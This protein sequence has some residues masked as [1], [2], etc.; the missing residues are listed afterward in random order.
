MQHHEATIAKYSDLVRTRPDVLALIIGGS[1]ARGTER[2]DSDV[3]VYLAVNEDAFD[4]ARRASTLSYTV[5]DVATYDGGY[6]D[7]KVIGT[8]WL[9]A[10]A[11]HADEPTRASLLGAR[12]EWSKLADLEE[13]LDA[14][15]APRDD[16]WWESIVAT[17]A[18]TYRLYGAYFLHQGVTLENAF[19]T[20]TAASRFAEAVGRA[21]LARN[22][23]F[24]AGPKY[25]FS[26]LRQIEGGEPLVR[27]LEALLRLP[28]VD[29]ATSIMTTVEP[30]IRANLAP[31]ATLS[32]FIEDHELAWLWNTTLGTPQVGSLKEE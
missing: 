27:E 23:V 20:S 32:R 19:L 9:D 26:S 17:H 10:A 25:L 6:V 4:E 11:D 5:T 12:V 18:A 22:R 16:T 28:S 3:D 31:E 30:L 2:A 24:Y 8:R 7:V 29:H 14:I 13:R 21:V 1:V 15:T